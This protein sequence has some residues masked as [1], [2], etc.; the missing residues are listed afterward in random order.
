MNEKEITREL[1]SRFGKVGLALLIYYMIM[2]VAVSLVSI[3]DAISCTFRL[4]L[5]PASNMTPE[6]VT[7][8]VTERM[9]SN[10]WG[11]ILAIAIGCV[12]LLIWKKKRFCFHDI[13]VPGKNMTAGAFVMILCI[14]TSG[15]ALF[16]IHATAT[17]WVL[18]HFGISLIDAM[19][20]ASPN[21]DT[22]S[23]FLYAGLFAPVFEEV[24][25]RGLILRTLEPYGKKFAILASAFCFGIFHGNLVQ[26]PYAFCVG[27]V[28]G[29]VAVE[30]SI[31]W[32]MVL[33]MFNN[34]IL[35]DTLPRLLQG[36]PQWG[37]E[38][39]FAVII[40]GSA[41]A[42]LGIL[43]AKRRQISAYLTEKKMHPLCLKAFFS[44]PAVI[45]LTVMMAGNALLMILMQFLA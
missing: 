20:S 18:N 45:I 37:Q 40:W 9:M 26:S 5:D 30:Y 31:G 44:A 43:L 35:G 16:Q 2:N 3:V 22:L 42:T 1:R 28:L 36:L 15:Q 13:W 4:L 41:V 25:F 19:E 33:H 6:E 14:F 7:A 10:G 21:M 24:L 29:Y 12:C 32:A 34:L 27:L 17:D 8:I 39:V 23:M 38:A 11:Y